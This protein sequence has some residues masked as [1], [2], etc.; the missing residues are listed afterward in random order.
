[1]KATFNAEQMHAVDRNLIENHGFPGIELMENA[2][3]GVTAEAIRILSGNGKQCLVLIGPGNNGGDGLAVL[4]QLTA[5]GFCAEG[6]LLFPPEKFRG[7]ALTEYERATRSGCALFSVRDACPDPLEGKDL[8]VDAV[9]GTGLK[10]PADDA[11]SSLFA[12]VNA[13]GIPVISVDLPSGLDSDSG[14]VRG[15][16]IRADITVT[17]QEYKTG[18]MTDNGRV[19]AG[20][21]LLH[22]I[23]GIPTTEK[24]DALWVGEEDVRRCLPGR[25]LNA[26]KGSSGRG[27]LLAGSS[28]YPGA[29]KLSAVAALRAGTGLLTAGVP[30]PV[31]P[32]FSDTPEIM[33]VPLGM[34]GVWDT[35]T[36]NDAAAL[37]PGKTALAMGPGMGEIADRE[38]FSALLSCGLPTVLDADALNR[39]ASEPGLMRYLG[40]K[41]VL[42][43]HPAEAARLLHVAPQEILRDMPGSA[44]RLARELNAV[45]LLKGATSWISDGDRLYLNTSGNPGLGKG[46]SG[47]TL[48]GIVLALLCQGLEPL[49]AAYC[50]AYL[51]GAAAD[52]AMSILG[53]RMLIAKDVTDAFAYVL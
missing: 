28:R 38:A 47:D 1:M 27:L 29:A 15:A 26:H 19:H 2:A 35:E 14:E 17:F 32:G 46:G 23:S 45:V 10:R 9:F 52:K 37:L 33:T 41:H 13:S 11:L 48:T 5:R 51:L 39:I 7:D 25:K 3:A 21:I 43:P 18:L 6:L 30:A 44:K 42:T 16:C 49:Q 20:K 12:R 50:G 22:P 24:P 8:I 31:R 53:E 4:R 40:K 36:L 34:S